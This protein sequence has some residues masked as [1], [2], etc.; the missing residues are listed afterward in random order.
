MRGSHFCFTNH[1]TEVHSNRHWFF[2]FLFFSKLQSAVE[3]AKKKEFV[4][5]VYD[6]KE[7]KKLLRTRTNVLVL[8]MKTSEY[9]P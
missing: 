3:S 4:E 2:N 7:F 1:L 6:V 9:Y 5:K 8:Y